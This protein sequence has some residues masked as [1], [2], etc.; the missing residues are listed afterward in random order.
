MSSQN[1][2]FRV[3]S[4]LSRL[5]DPH[6]HWMQL[7]NH[8]DLC[9]CCSVTKLCPLLC[10]TMICSLPVQYSFVVKNPK[11]DWTHICCIAGR[12][13][14][15][16]PLDRKKSVYHQEQH[17][18]SQSSSEVQK[19]HTFQASPRESCYLPGKADSG[20]RGLPTGLRSWHW[21]QRLPNHQLQKD[22]SCDATKPHH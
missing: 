16:E 3:P 18:G 9:C 10:D 5:S 7:R 11:C 19:S 21:W 15:T 1:R 22:K 4:T 6:Y 20:V 12:F 2:A 14:T 8:R 13:L 17:K